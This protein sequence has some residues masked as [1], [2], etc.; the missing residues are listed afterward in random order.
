MNGRKEKKKKGLHGWRAFLVVFASGTLAAFLVVGLIVGGL[1]LFAS[2]ITSGLQGEGSSSQGFVE[3]SAKPQV[4]VP[5]GK[6]DVCGR[7]LPTTDGI[8]ID[9]LDGEEDYH[10]DALGG[11]GESGERVVR[12]ECDWE[13]TP[14]YTSIN[15]WSFTFSYEAILESSGEDREDRAIRLFDDWKMESQKD[16]SEIINEGEGGYSDQSYFIYGEVEGGAEGAMSALV[17][18]RSAVYEMR[19][20]GDPGREERI[21]E[22]AFSHEIDNMVERL[23]QAFNARIPE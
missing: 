8:D 10:D 18:T 4:S 9:R 3:Q 16:F 23:D 11:E 1:R 12:D 22:G 13:L 5:P 21:P 20:V 7:T 19:I 17:R 6:L 2:T 14:A 15:K